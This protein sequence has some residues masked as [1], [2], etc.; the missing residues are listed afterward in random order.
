MISICIPT[1][2]YDVRPLVRE[3]AEQAAQAEIEVEILIADDSSGNEELKTGNREIS[4]MH[5]VHYLELEKNIGRSA[6]RNLLSQKS[7]FRLLLFLDCDTFPER[8]DFVEN[9]FRN[10]L[11]NGVVV[12]GLAYR[13]ALTDANCSLRWTYGHCRETISAEKRSLQPY[14][15][16]MTGN[17]MIAKSVFS[18]IQFNEKLKGYGHEDTYFGLALEQ[19]KIEIK[20]IENRVYHD[21]LEPN[22]LFIEKTKQ[23]IDNL[24]RIYLSD[25]ANSLF[26]SKN[27]LLKTFVRLHQLKVTS[28]GAMFFRIFEKRLLKNLTSKKPGIRTFDWYKLGYFCFI[29]KQH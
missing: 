16:F 28:F 23:G 17:F 20:H 7:T 3:L 25:P 12:G 13:A 10:S 14:R 24:L 6:I 15:S 9:Y 4:S 21:G 2:N 27:K 22:G 8:K 29:S 18:K 26:I 5:G 1:Y 11:S 19:N